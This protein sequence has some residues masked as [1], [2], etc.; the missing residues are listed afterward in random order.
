MYATFEG[1]DRFV[2]EG[3]VEAFVSQFHGHPGCRSE[4][5]PVPDGPGGSSVLPADA[6]DL[7]NEELHDLFD[8]AGFKVVR[9]PAFTPIASQE[10]TTEAGE[11]L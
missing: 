10:V 2:E 6:K 9:V 4:L 7:G 5:G 1:F 3:G 8:A 11:G